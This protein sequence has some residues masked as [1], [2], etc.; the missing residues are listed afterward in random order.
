[1]QRRGFDSRGMFR[2]SNPALRDDLFRGMGG[3][4]AAPGTTMTV[5]G[6]V[7]KTASLLLLL[8]FSAAA[9]WVL[10]DPAGNTPLLIGTALVG[11]VIAMATIFRPRWS[12][13]TAPVYALVEGVF[14]GMISEAYE[15]AFELPGIVLQAVGATV[16]VFAA[17]L[18]L[19]KARI[20]RVTQRFRAVVLSATLGIALFYLVSIVLSLFGVRVP[21]I[22]DASPI[23]IL[24]SVVIVGVAALN[25][26]LDF[27]FIERGA[28]AGAPRYMEWYGAFGLLVTLVWLYLELL[29]LLS[30]LRR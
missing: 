5:Q 16:A 18:F 22:N 27:D 2:T 9:T 6:A 12:P 3:T 4:L 7:N 11:F 8:M 15:T 24:I 21:F 10:I 19:Y 14:L 13:Y 20:I 26:V 30:K 23:G 28:Q 29:R 25:L 1:M 17:M